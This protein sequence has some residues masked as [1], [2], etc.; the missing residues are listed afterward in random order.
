MKKLQ[1]QLIYLLW[2]YPYKM[3][4]FSSP[5]SWMLSWEGAPASS[6]LFAPTIEG[7]STQPTAAESTLKCDCFYSPRRTL[8]TCPPLR[9]FSVGDRMGHGSGPI[10]VA[11]QS[12]LLLCLVSLSFSL[13]F[14]QSTLTEMEYTNYIG[15]TMQRL[16]ERCG[17]PSQA[18]KHTQR[19]N[20]WSTF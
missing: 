13:I 14:N 11:S 18:K 6:C 12:V 20:P 10:S 9:P 15:C 3:A 4:E 2:V 1:Y 16:A 17:R 19:L 7:V 5:S 8:Q